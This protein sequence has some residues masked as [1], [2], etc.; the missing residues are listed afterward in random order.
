MYDCIKGILKS[1]NDLIISRYGKDLLSIAVFGS[2]ARGDFNSES[3]RDMIIVA[4]RDESR[5][6]KG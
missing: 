1:A 6:I 3:D 4:N 5:G 2:L